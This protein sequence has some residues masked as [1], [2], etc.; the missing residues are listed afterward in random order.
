MDGKE[1]NNELEDADELLH[2]PGEIQK[3]RE[4]Y[5]WNWIDLENKITGC[6]TIGIIP[7]EHRRELFFFLFVDNKRIIYYREPTLHEYIDDI[8]V[9]LQDKRLA[10]KLIT[11]YQN[12][13]II[14]EC[15]KF[16]FKI[17]WDTRFNTHVFKKDFSVAWH[18]HFESSGIITGEIK[19]KDACYLLEGKRAGALRGR[20][21][22]GLKAMI[23][24]NV[25]YYNTVYREAT[26]R[27]R[28]LKKGNYL[29]EIGD[30]VARYSI[31]I[32]P[33]LLDVI[34]DSVRKF[35]VSRMLDIG[36]GTGVYLCTAAD[37]NPDLKGIG[38]ES[39]PKAAGIARQILGDPLNIS[40]LE[41]GV[42]KWS[43][44]KYILEIDKNKILSW[45]KVGSD[46]KITDNISVTVQSSI[47]NNRRSHGFESSS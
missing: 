21:G 16:K 4:A 41:G 25:T 33:Y 26:P 24:G 35:S 29:D 46:I 13:E 12:W 37:E 39:D 9:M 18:T 34:I 43:F 32:E 14:Y 40:T 28:S 2:K 19:Y 38:I 8:E 47:K 3:W 6:S 20:L 1:K 11:P 44:E 36:C 30:I 27:M 17:N 10:Y 22:D 7:N 5:Y 42:E 45:Q 15:P 23:Q 31:L